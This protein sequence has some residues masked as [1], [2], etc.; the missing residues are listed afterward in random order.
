MRFTVVDV[1]PKATILIVDDE[2]SLRGLCEEVLS[3]AGYATHTVG[4]GP[5]ALQLL[6][7]T[8]DIDLVVSDL[9]MPGMSG[10]DLLKKIKE[11]SWDV[12]F[13]IMTGFSSIETAVE[14]MRLGAADYLPKPFNISHLLLKVEKI[15]QARRNRKDRKKLS[16]L[17]RILNLSQAMNTKLDMKSLVNEFL[18]QVQKNF[19]PDGIALFLEEKSSLLPK[20]TR[21]GL[22][23]TNP[24]LN[25]WVKRLGERI[26]RQQLPEL[27]MCKGEGIACS[28]S[29]GP[30]PE[31]LVSSVIVAP[32]AIRRKSVGSV[33]LLRGNDKPAYT[34]EQLQLLYV[35]AVHTASAFEN[36]RL[37]A[38]MRDM[39]LEVI[40]SFAQ[41]VEAKDVYTRGHSERVALYATHLGGRLGLSQEDMNRLYAAGILHDIG[42]I[43]IPESIL[44]KP[45]KLTNEE[46]AVMQRHP[47]LGRAI[48]NQTTAFGDIL[49]IIYHHHEHVDGTGYPMG[50]RGE[51]IP[52]LARMLSVV[53]AFE[54][55]TSDRAYRK[56][57]LV[58][59]VREI[60][61]SGAGRQWQEDLVVLWLEEIDKPEFASLHRYNGA[62]AIFGASLSDGQHG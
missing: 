36:A 44:N 47:E 18:S 48:L 1:E 32:I 45:A 35:F 21:G 19:A 34:R 6:N 24:R 3:D 15:L 58:E 43:G 4:D 27:I 51:E 30:P 9:R 10:L 31:P 46:F 38:Q 26:F 8:K 12:D 41:A 7:K 49:P 62:S 16:N 14:S 53:D 42:K 40:R 23:R 61:A 2:S 57:L 56:A 11:G 33:V 37:Y 50:L 28:N 54:A 13:L 20:V 25:S 55:M 60:L 5:S 52:F 17:V 29:E 22:L 59:A 39:N